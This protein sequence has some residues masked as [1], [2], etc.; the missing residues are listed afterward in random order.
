MHPAAL[1]ALI[2]RFHPVTTEVALNLDL[3][4]T[5]RVISLPSWLTR[6]GVA[7]GADL[8]L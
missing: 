2:E 6:S 3:A 7:Q 5:E 4:D 1:R 8:L